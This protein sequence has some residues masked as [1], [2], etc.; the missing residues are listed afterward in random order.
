MKK[1]LRYFVIGAIILTLLIGTAIGQT[2]TSTI[3]VVY[4]SVNLTVN[5]QKIN[6]DNIL[7]NGTTYVPLRA[8]AEALDKEVGWNQETKTATINDKAETVKVIRVVDGDTLV[9]NFQGREEKVRLIGIDT[10]ESVHPD[11]SKNV[12]EGKIASNFTKDKLEGK[13]IELEFDVQER[14]QYGRLLAYV[15]L[16]GVMFNKTLLAE[17]YAQ[18]STYPPNVKYVEEFTETQRTAR[19][20]N[21]GLWNEEN[22]NNEVVLEVKT[23][24]NYVGSLNSDKYHKPS[25]RYAKNIESYNE[26]WFDTTDEAQNAGYTACGVC[27]P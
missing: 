14:D 12:E 8:V 6:A 16:D 19:E 21:K 1:V 20:N 7:Y 24:G 3:E 11:A 22:F 2:I 26:I 17:G 27:K 13:E 15:Y 5:G 9:V 4:N 18:V 10:P 23:S 25:C